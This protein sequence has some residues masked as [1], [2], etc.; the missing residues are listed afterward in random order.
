MHTALGQGWGAP[1]GL[2]YLLQLLPIS[3]SKSGH[4]WL[5]RQELTGAETPSGSCSEAA[6]RADV[7]SATSRPFTDTTSYL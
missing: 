6:K 1:G 7:A 2:T 3:G 4:V 5:A